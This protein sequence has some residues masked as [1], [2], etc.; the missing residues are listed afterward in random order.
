MQSQFSDN[1]QFRG[2]FVKDHFQFISCIKFLHLVS[3]VSLNFSMIY[4]DNIQTNL[5]TIFLMIKFIYS[6]KAAKYMNFTL[7]TLFK[8][9]LTSEL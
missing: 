5:L 2:Y 4:F 7:S 3:K 1:L 9:V 8:A 6:E